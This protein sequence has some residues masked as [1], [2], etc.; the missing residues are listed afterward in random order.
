MTTTEHIELLPQGEGRYSIMY[1]GEDA[2]ELIIR[3]NQTPIN[4]AYYG[5]VEYEVKPKFRGVGLAGKACEIVEP[6]LVKSGIEKLWFT[7]RD[8]N[9]PSISTIEKLG[10]AFLGKLMLPNGEHRRRYLWRLVSK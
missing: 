1:W 5:H 4:A 2:G 7:V 6:I 8:N 9:Y 3:T 10:C